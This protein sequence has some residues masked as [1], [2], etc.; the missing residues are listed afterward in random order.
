MG[1]GAP[2]KTKAHSKKGGPL[3]VF[4]GLEAAQQRDDSPRWLPPSRAGNGMHADSMKLQQSAF[5]TS[6]DAA[7]AGT[8]NAGAGLLRG[9]LVGDF[10]VEAFTDAGDEHLPYRLHLLAHAGVLGVA[11]LV[12]DQALGGHGGLGSRGPA[13]PGLLRPGV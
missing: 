9:Q 3:T 7:E 13:G 1:V 6:A 12:H 8:R 5:K 11:H 10:L 2:Q 4:A